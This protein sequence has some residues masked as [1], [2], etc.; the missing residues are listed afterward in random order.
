MKIGILT[1]H[2]AHNYG[3][4][5]QCYATQ[6]FLR[7]KGYD[8]EVINYRPYYLL[9]PY[10]LFNYRRVLC[11]NPIRLIKKFIQEL[12]LFPVRY[13]RWR[14]FEGFINE[15]LQ[16]GSVVTNKLP[17][18]CDVYLIG[19]DQVWNPKITNGFDDVYFA[20]FP[21]AKAKKRYVAYAA[22]MEAKK[23]KNEGMSYL[24]TTSISLGKSF[25]SSNETSF[26]SFIHF[27]KSSFASLT[28]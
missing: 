27:M 20:Q 8:V 18:D 17:I 28:E 13:K 24:N 15:Q 26:I 16:L 1:F 21:F 6:E 9:H 14:A 22:S 12:L 4:V 11:K 3:A 23:L 2:C 5:L 7:G 25:P 10:Q 19:S